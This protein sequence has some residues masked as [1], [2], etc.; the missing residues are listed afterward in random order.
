MHTKP[1]DICLFDNPPLRFERKSLGQLVLCI[2][3]QLPKVLS[4]HFKHGVVGSMP[5]WV[6]HNS[7][8]VHYSSLL[9]TQCYRKQLANGL[10]IFYKLPWSYGLRTIKGDS[11]VL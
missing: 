1:L 7:K 11:K 3:L 6:I 9:S 4:T 2:L 10:P 8:T 5:A